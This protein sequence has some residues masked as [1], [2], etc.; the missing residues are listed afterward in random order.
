M[1]SSSV[2]IREQKSKQITT[3]PMNAGKKT[4]EELEDHYR[5]VGHK[6][7]VSTLVTTLHIIK[8]LTRL[9]SIS[10]LSLVGIIVGRTGS[11]VRLVDSVGRGS[12]VGH[13]IIPEQYQKIIHF[14]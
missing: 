3:L 13:S 1:F 6:K 11:D 9:P 2:Q 14:K 12:F 10:T 4:R 8:S 7:E 5:A